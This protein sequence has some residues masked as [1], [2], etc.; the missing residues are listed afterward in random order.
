METKLLASVI[1]DRKVWNYLKEEISPKEFSPEGELIYGLVTEFYDADPSATR[2]DPEILSARAGRDVTSN[3]LSGIVKGAITDLSR[4]DCSAANIAKEVVAVRQS[5]LGNR[6]AS[7]LAAGRVTPDV[8]ELMNEYL[9]LEAKSSSGDMGE[10]SE[11]EET[12]R[13]TTAASLATTT[14]STKGLIQLYPLVLNT[15]IDGGLRGGHHVLI[16][17]P[18]EMGKSLFAINACYGF[19]KQGLTVLYVENEDPASDTLMRMMTRLTGMTKYEIL[20]KPEKADGILANRNWDRFVLANLSPGTF[21]KIDQLAEEFKAQVVVLNQLHNIDVD[22][23]NRTQALEKSATEAR[24]LAKRRGI[25]VLSVTQAADS[26]SGKTIL[27]RGDVNGSNIGIPGQ[28]DLMIGMGATQEMEER[29]LRTLSFQKNKLS[30]KHTPIQIQIDP[31][32]SRIM[33]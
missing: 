3:K 9:R 8:K 20:E 7:K 31:F 28:I 16:F 10:R 30:G 14:F 18:T 22:T 33:E 32:L 12:F 15:H 25:P 21:S 17:A 2:C 13:S 6:I 19:L 24:N 4:M 26:A 27:D 23:E 11:G 1:Q 29:N 5:T